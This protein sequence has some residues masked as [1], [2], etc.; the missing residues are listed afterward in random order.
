MR[1]VVIHGH[2]YQ[3]PREEPWLELVPCEP[4]AAPDHDWNSRITRECYAPLAR[5]FNVGATLFRWFDT[6][7]PRVAVALKAGDKASRARLGYG[8]AIAMPYHHLIMPLAS[9]RDKLT[10]VRWGIR[11][12]RGRFG[13]DPEGMWLPE[14]AVDNETLDVLAAEGI[15][16]TILSP[17]QVTAPPTGAA[18]RG[19][20]WPS[21]ATTA[22]WHT[23]WRSV[24]PSA[25]PNGWSN[26]WLTRRWLRMTVQ[27]SHRSLPMGRPLA[28]I[29]GTVTA[30]SPRSS[31]GL[32]AANR[33]NSRTTPRSWRRILPAKM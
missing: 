14:T 17:P 9:R 7:A 20:S 30:R 21:S 3:P 29:I 18:R 19:T 25:L 26:A 13:R 11:D 16:F 15:R 1:H 8:N 10:E 23:P 2:F 6:H 31:I 32:K 24:M 4:T 33:S 5:S 12:F 27:P 22:P 28:I